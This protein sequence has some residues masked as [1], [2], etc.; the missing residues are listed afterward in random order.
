M[1]VDAIDQRA[2][3]TIV[4]HLEASDA[5]MRVAQL[6]VLGGAVAA[7]P[8][9]STA[10]AHRQSPIMVNVASV[11][12]DP[13]KAA[14]GRRFAMVEKRRPAVLQT[15]GATGLGAGAG[16]VVQSTPTGAGP[17]VLASAT[18]LLEPPTA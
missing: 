4:D 1:F 14:P 16:A 10:Y 3:A 17:A 11:D 9:D 15:V 5:P 8:A 13:D 18:R 6:R 2:A 7:V 12:E